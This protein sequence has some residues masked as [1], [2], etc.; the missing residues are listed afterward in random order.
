MSYMLRQLLKHH[1][2]QPV[3]SKRRESLFALN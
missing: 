3:S 2:I 1:H